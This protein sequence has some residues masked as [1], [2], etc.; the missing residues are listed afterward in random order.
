MADE[1]NTDDPLQFGSKMPIP[2]GLVEDT[3]E[4]LGAEGITHFTGYKKDHGTVSPV[5]VTEGGFPHPVHF[6]EGMSVRN[7]MRKSAHCEGW[8]D[9]EFDDSWQTLIERVIDG[10]E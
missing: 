3:R 8:G 1:L 2:D 10:H 7:F 9:H 5:I 4:W 6:H